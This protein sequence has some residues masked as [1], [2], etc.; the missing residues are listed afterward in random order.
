MKQYAALNERN[1]AIHQRHKELL[2]IVLKLKKQEKDLL[3]KN[4]SLL[5]NG[6]GRVNEVR[7][8][9]NALVSA[10]TAME[11]SPASE[12]DKLLSQVAA[13]MGCHGAAVRSAHL[14]ER[15]VQNLGDRIRRTRH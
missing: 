3:Q 12:T 2:A 5:D 15:Q 7:D 6:R 13:A 4:Y 9:M 11:T 8:Q 10:V 14:M 1:T